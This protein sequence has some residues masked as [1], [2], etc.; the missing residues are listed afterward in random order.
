MVVSII[1][2]GKLK[3]AGIRETCDAYA[4]RIRAR[5]RLEIVEVRA[6]GRPEADANVARVREADSLRRAAGR[7]AR[8]FCLTRG[9]P[10]RTS[11]DFADLLRRWREDSRDVAIMIG[12]AFGIDGSLLDEAEGTISLSPMTLPH[13]LARVVLLEQLYRADTILHAEPYHKGS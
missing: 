6:A 11:E 1:A 8:I 4:K 12:G 10:A 2:V 7:T 3:Q 9:G 5:Q 13:E